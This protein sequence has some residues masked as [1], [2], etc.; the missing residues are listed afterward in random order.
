MAH[1]WYTTSFLALVALVIGPQLVQTLD[2]EYC[3]DI[4]TAAT[5]LNTSIYQS[6]GLCHDY[7]VEKTF[8]F[9]IVQD[10]ACWCSDYAPTKSSQVDTGECSD[11]CP[12]WKY[13]TCGASGLYGY[14]QLDTMPSGTADGGSTSSPTEQTS[15]SVQTSSTVT[16][17]V[18][19][20]TTRTSSTPL[21]TS[22]K[23]SSTTSATPTTSV[24][25]VTAGGTV[26]LET[27]TV[28][29]TAAAGSGDNMSSSG[30]LSTGATAGIAIGVI[31]IVAILAGIAAFFYLQRKR[32]QRE[33]EIAS[34]SDSRFSGS[35]GI[36]S[37]P[38]TTMASVWDG[39]NTSTGRRSSRLMPHDPRMDPFA[40]NIYSRFDNKSRESIN[41]L[42][43][44]Q[45][46][47]RKVLRTT[48]PDPPD[49]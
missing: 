44:N 45:D 1:W 9:A 31:A 21:E 33:E 4:N 25:T 34:R 13:E 27:V 32:R 40:T 14:I 5:A 42:Q 39:E 30:G 24:K 15:T 7:C 46:Y 6:N 29:P 35:A 26:S 18:H 20:T 47:S 19:S 16:S 17:V 43:D 22:T 49:Q 48:N 11:P 23:M 37:T 28:T 36:M 38:T 2:M 8:A 41:T 12:G 10:K 3:A